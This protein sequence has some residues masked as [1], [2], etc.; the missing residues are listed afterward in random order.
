[1]CFSFALHIV[2]SMGEF[3]ETQKSCLAQDK[4]IS[5][6]FSSCLQ[7]SSLA[8]ISCCRVVVQFMT[9]IAL[10]PEKYK[11]SPINPGKMKE[12]KTYPYEKICCKEYPQI[13][14]DSLQE[15]RVSY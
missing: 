4:G 8:A 11:S 1:M 2:L 3:R 13:R 14:N 6:I 10:S 9:S 12:A 15:C 7:N 5:G